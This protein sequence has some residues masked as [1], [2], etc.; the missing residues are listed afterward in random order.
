MY[1]RVEQIEL[2]FATRRNTGV[3]DESQYFLASLGS[4]TF[5]HYS[6]S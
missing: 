4:L 3:S 1:G 2:S 5:E 6:I